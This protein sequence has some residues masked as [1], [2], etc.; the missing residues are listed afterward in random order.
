ME[1]N[2]NMDLDNMLNDTQETNNVEV[3]Q[4]IKNDFVEKP[5]VKKVKKDINILSYSGLNDLYVKKEKS[6][7]AKKKQIEKLIMEVDKLEIEMKE[8]TPLLIQ[9]LQKKI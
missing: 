3:K 2:N 8:I 1:D 4:E 5:I 9:A 6:Q 7:I